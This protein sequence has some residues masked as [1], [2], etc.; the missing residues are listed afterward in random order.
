MFLIE[1]YLYDI[2]YKKYFSYDEL[3]N[4]LISYFGVDLVFDFFVKFNSVNFVNFFNNRILVL[5]IYSYSKHKNIYNFFKG[6]DFND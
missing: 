6:C 2:Y 5:N 4:F 3:T 1:Y